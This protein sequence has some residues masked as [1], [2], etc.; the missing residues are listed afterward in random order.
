VAGPIAVYGASGYTGRLVA[1]ELARRGFEFVLSGRNA[2]RLRR[3]AHE[4]GRDVPVRAAEIDDRDGLRHALGDCAAVIN[5]AGPFVRFGEPVVRA[6]VETGTHY[7][8]TTGE[9]PFM[10][11]VAE[12]YDDPARAAEIAVVCAM[13]FDY[14]PG[15]MISALAGRGHE[16]LDELVVAYSVRG[17]GVTRGTLRS[18]L[19]VL[20]GGDLTYEEGTWR[21]AGRGPVRASFPFPEP[22]GRQAVVK[23]P[24]GEIVTVPRHLRTRK[25]TSLITAST[26]APLPGL[27]PLLPVTMPA[28]SLS[29]RTPLRAALS[30]AIGHLPEGPSEEDRERAEFT[31][32]AVACGEDGTT[33]RGVV[34]GTDLYGLTAVSAVHGA[35]LMAGEGYDRIG[36][37]PPAAAYD[38]VRFLNYLGGHGVTYE[39]DL[40]PE[41]APAV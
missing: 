18:T 19:E 28:I 20:K 11:L 17:S 36:A 9:Q 30:V 13:G 12:R 5:C 41:R 3:V 1:H 29:L 25:V 8:D 16:P 22:L 7:V 23:Y 37:L 40:A 32:V 21:P 15:D 38:P 34:R 24:S 2:E 6:A 4:V 26:V 14:V 27:A 33:G 39:L 31:I 35:S 10:Q